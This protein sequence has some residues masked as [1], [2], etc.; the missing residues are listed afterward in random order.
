MS[1]GKFKIVCFAL[2]TVLLSLTL[3]AATNVITATAHPAQDDCIVKGEEVAKNETVPDSLP[4]TIKQVGQIGGPTQAVAVQGNYAYVGMGLRLLVL[5]VSNPAAPQEV[6]ATEPLGG[7]LKDVAIEGNTAYVVDSAGLWVVD[8]SNPAHPNEVGFYSTPGY[9]EGV[10]VA[11]RY[12]YVA[13]GWA[14]L[15]VM[16]ISDQAN[17]TE[18]G[19][20]YTLGYAFD[21][22][23]AGDMAYVAGAG[24]GLRIVDISNPAHPTEVGFYDT[25]GYT[26]DIAVAGDIAYIADEWEGL[27]VIDIS[28]PTSPIEVGYHSTLGQAFGVAVEE[29]TVYIADAFKGLRVIDVSSPS[30]PK[31][32]GACEVKGHAGTVVVAG[33]RVYI[34]DRKNG[35]RIIDISNLYS[36]T[37]IGIYLALGYAE[38]VTV[39]GNYAYVAAGSDGL[40]VVDISNP[41]RARQVGHYDC[42]GY[43]TNVAVDGNYVYVTTGFNFSESGASLHIVDV[44][45]PSKPSM[46]A[47]SK[48]GINP[49]Y[50]DIVVSDGI[51]YIANGRGLV[52]VMNP[53]DPFE[54]GYIPLTTQDLSIMTTGLDVS[55]TLAYMASDEL[56]VNIV[57]VSNPQNL[58]LIGTFSSESFFAGDITVVGDRAYVAADKGGLVVLDVSNS[59]KPLEMGSFETQGRAV[60]VAVDG[61]TAYVATGKSG[62]SAVDISDPFSLRLITKYN[63]PGYAYEVVVKNNLLYVAD[64]DAGLLVFEVVPSNALKNQVFYQSNE[65]LIDY[66]QIVESTIIYSGV[67]GYA[68]A[69]EL[70]S[71]LATNIPDNLSSNT[72]VVN[73]TADSGEGSLRKCLENARYGDTIIFDS[74]IF[75][76]DNPAMISLSSPLP[77]ITQGNITIDASNAGVILDGNELQDCMGINLDSDRNIIRGLQI[78]FFPDAGINIEG[79]DNTIGGDR[80]GGK[81]PVGQGNVVSGN[82]GNGAII[83][84]GD[85]NTVIG[86]LIGTDVSGYMVIGNEGIGVHIFGRNNRIGGT[87]PWER[88]IISGNGYAGVSPHYTGSNGNSIIGNY[89]GTDISGSYDFG[90]A[91]DGIAIEQGAFNNLV[92]ENLISGN[93]GAGVTIWDWGSSYN[94]VV[95]N[96][97]GLDASGKEPLGNGLGVSVGGRAEFNRIGGITAEE[98]NII[99]GNNGGGVSLGG[100]G[101]VENLV[102]GN[103][104]GTD[105]TGTRALGNTGAGVN[106]EGTYSFVGGLTEEERNVIS[107]NDIGVNLSGL[108]VEYN[109]IAG[110]YIGTDVNG[111]V[112]LGNAYGVTMSNGA[113]RNVVQDNLISGNLEGGVNIQGDRE[114]ASFNLLWAN[115]IGTAAD[116]VSPLSNGRDGLFIE[117]S[118]N[119]AVGNIIAYNGNYGI[120]VSDVGFNLIFKNDLINNQVQAID[121]GNNRWDYNGEGN[122]WSDYTCADK[123]GDGIGDTP[124]Y[125]HLNAIDNYPFMNRVAETP[126]FFRPITAP[127]PARFTVTDLSI[128]PAGVKAGESTIV[129]VTVTNIGE[130]EGSYAVELKI[131]DEVVDNKKVTLKAGESTPVDFTIIKE[132]GL[133]DVS[134]KEQTGAF[135]VIA[136]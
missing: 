103:F 15:R 89:I 53:N 83:I 131:N 1:T 29:D 78:L 14:G 86:N 130:Q 110:N 18:V 96:T 121:R 34:T 87:Q 10:T 79:N 28:E 71:S 112:S 95:G 94:T 4:T 74:L 37:Q 73:T 107:G 75:P 26:H 135:V 127:I 25:Q 120:L 109:W 61:D 117:V 19:F 102:L 13:D 128:R 68:I 99:S 66:S 38:A 136:D 104:I 111:T 98:R 91:G 88:N 5:D 101:G 108:G 63:T 3:F 56:G 69:C 42:Q 90:N 45:N 2:C 133:Y 55:E 30:S 57:D 44:S 6:G 12:A 7:F 54:D 72:L 134:V 60:H 23:V 106:F 77:A 93:D 8:V 16:D 65:P 32:L 92:K 82:G 39:S 62:F 129:N 64:G 132:A 70:S 123:N 67:I 105:V 40:R 50:L 118:S 11:G 21:V 113:A 76:P 9:A 100:G 43:A 27:R 114:D 24:A 122:Y 31:E 115:R 52:V 119:T 51:A 20:V 22:T 81:G 80:G 35:L 116:G 59:A 47:L 58:T 126:V 49:E 125:I 17:L 84:S 97:I 41:V 36:P 33:N 85:D 124:Y 46:V 48:E